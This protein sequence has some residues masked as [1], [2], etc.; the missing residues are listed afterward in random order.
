MILSIANFKGGTAKTTT[1]FNLAAGLHEAGNKVLMVDVDAQSNLTY[2]YNLYGDLD[3]SM[4][5][6]MKSIRDGE[7]PQTKDAIFKVQG[8]HILPASIELAKADLEFSGVGRREYM[9]KRII[10]PVVDDYDFILID[11]P[12][13]MGLMT[14]N[15]LAITDYV[16]IPTLA[17]FLPF[18]GIDIFIQAV[19]RFIVKDEINTGLD[20]GGILFVQYNPQPILSRELYQVVAEEFPEYIFK[21]VIRRNIALSEAQSEGRSIFDYAPESNGAKDYRAL[22]E[23]FTQRFS[24]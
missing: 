14:V 18:K 23:E 6:L 17:E 22:V 19:K 1:T 9:M 13:S 15:S 7:D 5:D 8:P 21:T 2:S 16:I 4:Y 12:P 11:C 3:I 20:I 24:A 10:A